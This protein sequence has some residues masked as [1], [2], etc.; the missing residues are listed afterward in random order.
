MSERC[1]HTTAGA[2][3]GQKRAL[4]PVELWLKVVVRGPTGAAS[5]I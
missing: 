3:I 4:Y 2:C 5:Q 1:V